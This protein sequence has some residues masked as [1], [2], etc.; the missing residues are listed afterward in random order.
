MA[1]PRFR[2][3][4]WPRATWE[5]IRVS[6]DRVDQ[7]AYEAASDVLFLDGCETGLNAR[8]PGYS[9]ARPG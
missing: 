9:G 4:A 2:P 7:G 6:S 8:E 3:A 1:A 5:A